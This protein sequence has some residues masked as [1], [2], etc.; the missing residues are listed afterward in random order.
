[1][2]GARKGQWPRA[3]TGAL[4]QSALHFVARRPRAQLPGERAARAD[5]VEARGLE[6]CGT[7]GVDIASMQCNTSF[8]E[9]N[10]VLAW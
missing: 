6:G 2:A 8:T 3:L 7:K 10:L 1:M 9:M 4:G 5:I